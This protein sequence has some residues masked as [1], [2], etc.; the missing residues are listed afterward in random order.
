MI[1]HLDTEIQLSIIDYGNA[2][3]FDEK[4]CEEICASS[5]RPFES[6]FKQVVTDKADVFS[7][8]CIMF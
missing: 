8:A 6:H 4:Y 7:T 1:I 2:V 3:T 5:F